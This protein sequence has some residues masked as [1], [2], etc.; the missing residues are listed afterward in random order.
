MGALPPARARTRCCPRRL[1]LQETVDRQAAELTSANAQLEQLQGQVRPAALTPAHISPI[2]PLSRARPPCCCLQCQDLHQQRQVLLTNMSS[3]FKTAQMELAR[4]AA[5]LNSTRQ[6]VWQLQ[7]AAKAG[8]QPPGPSAPPAT[9]HPGPQPP[10]PTAADGR[11]AGLR[12]GAAAGGA[13]PRAE[14]AAA[15]NLERGQ[16]GGPGGPPAA[17]PGSARGE[18]VRVGEAQPPAGRQDGSRRDPLQQRQHQ[19]HG[20]QQGGQW[21][22]RGRQQPR[23]GRE[24]GG[25]PGKGSP[26]RSGSRHGSSHPQGYRSENRS[27]VRR[28]SRSRSPARRDA[29]AGERGGWGSKQGPSGQPGR[30]DRRGARD[31]SP[32]AD[33]RWEPRAGRGQ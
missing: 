13:P 21:Q 6:Q 14:A 27:D 25:G 22:E 7:A 16:A 8:R 24:E 33:P 9:R 18:A 31:R 15:W 20:Q 11:A 32:M 4:K 3:L 12:L 29:R 26:Q 30:D 5:E 10:P 17:P 28:R 19:Q 23:G 2:S 1:Q